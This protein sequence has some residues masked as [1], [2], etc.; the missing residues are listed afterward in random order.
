MVSGF[1]P[2]RPGSPLSK[3]SSVAISSAESSK[4][5]ISR[6]SCIRSRCIDF[7]KM[8]WPRWMCHRSVTC[9]VVFP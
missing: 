7:G 5:K 2:V 3:P 9:A 1:G 8:M 4:S 6:F